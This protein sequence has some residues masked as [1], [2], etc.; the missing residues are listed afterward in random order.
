VIPAREYGVREPLSRFDPA[1]VM[2]PG[3][4]PNGSVTAGALG[5]VDAAGD[6]SACSVV[7]VV[8][9]TCDSVDCTL[10]PADVPTA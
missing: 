3:C 4:K 10:V 8:V 6:A 9:T 2:S 7:G 1:F 5:A